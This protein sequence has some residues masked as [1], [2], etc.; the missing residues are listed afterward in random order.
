[1]LNQRVHSS[2]LCTPTIAK[3]QKQ[4]RKIKATKRGF[5]RPR[6]HCAQRRYHFRVLRPFLI[7]IHNNL[8]RIGEGSRVLSSMR[9]PHTLLA[10]AVGAALSAAAVNATSELRIID[11]DTVALGWRIRLE[12][13]RYR[14]AGIDA[15]ETRGARCPNERALGT[16]AAL[17]LR[18]LVAGGN[19]VLATKAA[20]DK[21]GRQ[22][23][24]L[25]Q[26]GHDV[27][28]TL[29]AEGLARPYDGRSRRAGWC[30]SPTGDKAPK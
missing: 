18:E 22:I 28:E 19:A 30:V 2:N 6:Y 26:N 10:L 24:S 9:K 12:E 7:A 3:P 20:K 17:R 27:G 8:H 21:Y 29:I 5:S 16:K 4:R 1:T 23:A 14:L 25:S 15:P 13:A 11:G